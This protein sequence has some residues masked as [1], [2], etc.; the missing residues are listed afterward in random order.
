MIT[1][2]NGLKTL[3]KHLSYECKCKFN[4]RKCN[5]DQKWNNDKYWCE[6]KKHHLSEKDYIWNPATCNREND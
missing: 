5:S 1:G 3:T 6:C 2:I 4:G